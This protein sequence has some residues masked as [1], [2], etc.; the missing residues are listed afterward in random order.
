MNAKIGFLGLIGVGIAGYSST[1]SYHSDEY[2]EKV[3]PA[4][5]ENGQKIEV[6]LGPKEEDAVLI[7]KVEGQYYCVSNKCPHFGFNL[8]K[9]VLFHDKIVCPLHNAS[10]SVKD[11]NAEG[12]PIVNGLERFE[13][14]E[15]DGNLHIKVPKAKLNVP[16]PMDMVKRDANDK[17]N[18]VIIGGGPAGISAAETLRQSGYTG[19]I[20]ILAKEKHVPYDRTILSKALFFADINKL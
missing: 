14:V 2:Y 12:G 3:I 7:V 19:K 13:V 4:T 5:L 15:K 17:R 16:R 9:G 1:Q 6:Q 20:T 10:F 18:Y 11:G 8:S